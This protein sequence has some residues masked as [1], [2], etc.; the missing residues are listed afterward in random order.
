MKFMVCAFGEPEEYAYIPNIHELG[1]GVELQSYGLKGCVSPAAWEER[2]R[3][4]RAF[5]ERYE[6]PLAVHG[7]FIGLEY[8]YHDHL[9]HA[10]MIER[11]DMTFNAVKQLKAD[12]VVLHSGFKLE[13]FLFNYREMW[14]ED[15]AKFWREEIRRYADLGVEV[16]MENVV[17]P[18]PELM[19]ELHDAVAH[20]NFKL[21]LDVGHVNAWSKLTPSLWIEKFGSRLKHVHV[22]D[23]NSSFDEHLPMGQGNLNFQAVF[24]ALHDIAP[25]ATASLEVVSDSETILKNLKDMIRRY[26]R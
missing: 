1:A 4:H 26:D 3:T 20:E 11:M 10:A 16:V 5:R 22:H 6:G 23:N 12:R 21:C 2:L 18:Y 17:E 25:N 13:V 19:I 24:A 8:A 7:P 14:V 15:T 9:L